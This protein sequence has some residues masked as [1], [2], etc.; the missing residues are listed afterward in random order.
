[1]PSVRT[2]GPLVL[3]VLI[4]PLHLCPCGNGYRWRRKCEIDD[5]HRACLRFGRRRTIRYLDTAEQPVIFN[6]ARARYTGR[7]IKGVGVAGA[8]SITE[9][10]RRAHAYSPRIYQVWISLIG[11]ARYIRHKVVLYVLSCC[12]RA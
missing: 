6:I 2:C 5:I 11:Y 9:R 4:G 1:M 3:S 12:V 8:A 7:E 10:R